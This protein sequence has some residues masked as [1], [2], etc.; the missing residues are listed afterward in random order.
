MFGTTSFRVNVS[1]HRYA[2]TMQMGQRSDAA[3]LQTE[4]SF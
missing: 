4:M 3:I 2:Y 1:L